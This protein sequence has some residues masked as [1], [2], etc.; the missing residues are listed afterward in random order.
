[1]RRRPLRRLRQTAVHVLIVAAQIATLCVMLFGSR[2]AQAQGG[3]A[4]QAALFLLL[5]VSARAVGMGQAMMAAS[6]TG[7]GVWW[8]PAGVA[9]VRRGDA[10]LHHS[11][12]VI[13][14]SEALTVSAASSPLGVFAISAN[15]LDFGGDIPA[16]DNQGNVVGK[17]LPRNLAVIGTYATTI[18]RRLT[19]GVSYKLVQFRFDCEGLCPSLPTSQSSTSALDFGAQF[20]LPTRIP[21]TVGAAVRNVGVR[22]PSDESGESDPLPTRLQ[23]GASAR[24]VIP[25]QY[26]DD[27]EVTVSADVLDDFPLEKPLPRVGAEFGWEKT[28]FLRAG[29]VFSSG[30]TESG[31]PTLGIG[32]VARRLVIDFARVFAG[33]SADAGQAPTYLSLRLSF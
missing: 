20:A 6:G 31:G 1:M 3:T 28:A 7:D 25:S 8:N 32:F 12:S 26:A 33:L 18:R 24:Y 29:Y 14:T 27:A 23:V 13:G 9:G 4:D 17:I 2:R 15:I 22:L 5:P 30:S 21:V 19:A 16:V 11:Q 10:A